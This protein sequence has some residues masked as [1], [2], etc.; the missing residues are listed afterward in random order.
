MRGSGYGTQADQVASALRFYLEPQG[1]RRDL[2]FRCVVD[3]PYKYAPPCE[4]VALVEAVPP[5]GPGDPLV[6]VPLT[7]DVDPPDVDLVDYC[8]HK[9]RHVH[10]NYGPNDADVSYSS[11]ASCSD[12]P[13]QIACWGNGGES[14]E[15]SICTSCEPTPT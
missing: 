14:L 10:V 13:G 12:S 4:I 1:H 8:D 7:C 9:I 2:G 5:G 6:P 15:Y 3:D 11:D